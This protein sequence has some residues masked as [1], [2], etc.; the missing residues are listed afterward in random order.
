MDSD[1]LGLHSTNV[2][3]SELILVAKYHYVDVDVS[4]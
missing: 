2:Q 3:A 1:I 4:I